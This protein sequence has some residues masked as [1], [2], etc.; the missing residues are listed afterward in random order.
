MALH[1]TVGLRIVSV[2][3]LG[4][5]CGDRC[6][7]WHEH[8]IWLVGSVPCNVNWRFVRSSSATMVETNT[9]FGL[10]IIPSEHAT[11]PAGS[12]TFAGVICQAIF[13]SQRTALVG[14]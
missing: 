7:R 12:V 9:K 1:S 3:R 4:R 5:W 10:I 11:L 8:A 14:D 13:P 6:R 2:R